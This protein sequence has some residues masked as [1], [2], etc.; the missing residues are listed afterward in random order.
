MPLYEAAIGPARAAAARFFE[1]VDRRR[2]VV[3]FCH[4]DADGLAAGALFGR[5]LPRMGF[6]TVRVEPS[7]RGEAPFS[8]TARRRLRALRPAA[9]IVTDLGVDRA[10]VLAGVPTLY[11]DHHQPHGE[12][13]G[14]IVVSA[15]DWVPVP[16]AAWLTF[17]LLEPLCDLSDLAWLA[18]VGVVGDLGT[19]A[20]WPRL[21][22]IRKRFTAKWIDE[23]VSLVNAARRSSAADATTPLELLLRADHPRQIS[24]DHAGGAHKLRAYRVE[25]RRELDR[26]ARTAPRFSTDGRFALITFSS[27]CQIHPLVAQRWRTRLRNQ[28]VIAA[29]TGYLPGVVAFSARTARPH[30]DLPA[31]FQ[32]VDLGGFRSRLYGRG[33]AQASGG[34]LP[35][36]V[37][38]RMIERLGFPGEGRP[39]VEPRR[40]PPPRGS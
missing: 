40:A 28:I 13:P 18:A 6:E 5:A 26:A 36:R 39:I 21:A 32:S 37:F 22:A 3:V 35:P 31:L 4:F 8:D 33:H 24:S 19:R 14:A 2:P 11:V 17:E 15:H 9:L 29:N 10:G 25:V 20:P 27:P 7:R 16:S 1:G 38:D 34:H 12:P 30:V 23:A